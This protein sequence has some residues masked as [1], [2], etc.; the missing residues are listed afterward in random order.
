MAIPPLSFAAPSSASAEGAPINT[1]PSWAGGG[2][3]NVAT[4]QS[5]ASN[6]GSASASAGASG[7]ADWSTYIPIAFGILAL[8]IAWKLSKK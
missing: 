8:V 4:G 1:A 7:A 6:S 3:W 5:T 2:V